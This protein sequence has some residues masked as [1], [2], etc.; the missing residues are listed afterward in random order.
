MSDR[1]VAQSIDKIVSGEKPVTISGGVNLSQVFYA[2][3]GLESRR[4]PYNYF[5]SGN[6]NFDIYGFSVPLTFTYSNQQA[7]FR[8]H[9]QYFDDS[10]SQ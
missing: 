8:H 2:V 7:S 5:F 1:V 6:L 4:D 9:S 10:Q 3:S